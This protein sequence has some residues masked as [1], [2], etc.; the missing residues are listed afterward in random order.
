MEKI[1]RGLVIRFREPDVDFICCFAVVVDITIFIS[2]SSH[3]PTQ[4]LQE[5]ELTSF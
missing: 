3:S 1:I 4:P 2:F 5:K